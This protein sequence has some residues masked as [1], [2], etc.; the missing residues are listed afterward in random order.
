MAGTPGRFVSLPRLARADRRNVCRPEHSTVAVDH[1]VA[2]VVEPVAV[3][4]AGRWTQV[5]FHRLIWA[6]VGRSTVSP[7]PQTTTPAPRTLFAMEFTL[8]SGRLPAVVDV[9]V[10]VVLLTTGCWAQADKL[11]VVATASAATAA[12]RPTR[13]RHSSVTLERAPTVLTPP[14]SSTR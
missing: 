10:V 13:P 3:V 12:F 14:V 4:A 6:S 7:L 8:T 1:R 9:V 11:R 5:G 2:V